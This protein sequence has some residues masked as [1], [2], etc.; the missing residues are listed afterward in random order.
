[1]NTEIM[2]DRGNLFYRQSNYSISGISR[3]KDRIMFKYMCLYFWD[4]DV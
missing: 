1:M 4:K 3:T 2:L